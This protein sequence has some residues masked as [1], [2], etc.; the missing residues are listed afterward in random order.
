MALS[1][2]M[3]ASDFDEMRVDLPEDVVIHYGASI[4]TISAVVGDAGADEELLMA[5]TQRGGAV[6]IH[7]KVADFTAAGKAVPEADY[8]VTTRGVDYRVDKVTPAADGVTVI[9]DCVGDI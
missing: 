7:A 1:L 9:L 5:G 8:R 6:Q 4:L 3:L 2:T